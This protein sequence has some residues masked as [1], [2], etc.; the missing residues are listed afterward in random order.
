QGHVD[1]L[2]VAFTVLSVLCATSTRRGSRVVTGFLIGMATL[3]KIYPILLL[4]AIMRRRDWGLL[5]TC[6]ATIILG[7]IPY[8]ILGHGQVLGYVSTYS[9]EQEGTVCLIE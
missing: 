7:Y 6:L 3:T 8:F 1:A 9:V 2:P 5:A 4:V